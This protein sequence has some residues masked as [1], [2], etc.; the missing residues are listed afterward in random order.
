[1]LLITCYQVGFEID[2]PDS[3]VAC[4][5]GRRGRTALY[6]PGVCNSSPFL[7]NH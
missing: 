3:V 6:V 1:M 5:T 2:I 4:C 7:D